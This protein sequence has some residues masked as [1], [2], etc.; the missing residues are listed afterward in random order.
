M[1]LFRAFI[2]EG[3]RLSSVVALGLNHRA[4][5]DVPVGDYVIPKD[6]IVLGNINLMN[7]SDEIW[8]IVCLL[9]GA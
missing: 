9:A 6:A 4:A 8:P 2:H 1:H 3:I 5:E 7:T